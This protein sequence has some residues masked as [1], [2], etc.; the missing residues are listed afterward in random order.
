ML[1]GVRTDAVTAP[2][3]PLTALPRH[4]VAIAPPATKPTRPHCDV[5]L[6]TVDVGRLSADGTGVLGVHETFG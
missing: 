1:S 4:G 2:V 6:A 5:R 3:R